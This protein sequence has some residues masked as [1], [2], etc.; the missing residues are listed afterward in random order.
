MKKAFR[1]A[2]IIAR[3]G[4]DEFTIFTVDSS[5]DFIGELQTRLNRFISE[6]NRYWGKPYRISISIG[7]VPF[8]GEDNTNIEQLLAQADNLLYEQKRIKK[9]KRNGLLQDY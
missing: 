3:L 2:D 1:N 7:A 4:G 8:S 5:E 6:N 9:Q